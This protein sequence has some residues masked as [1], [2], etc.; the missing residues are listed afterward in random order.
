MAIRFFTE[1]IEFSLPQP[2]KT[3]I[4][5]K[6]IIESQ[7]FQ[8]GEINY[9]FADDEYILQIN[10]QYLQHDTYTDIITF[11]QRETEEK[12][13]SDIYISIERIKENAQNQKVTFEN[14]LKRVIIHG[15]WHLL[16]YGD[17]TEQEAKIMREKENQS[18]ILFSKKN[19]Y[20]KN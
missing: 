14:E 8:V 2:Q 1:N 13:D 17:K 7:G 18:L 10:Q 3:R 11:D 4:W 16:G 9:I 15:I 19:K 12:I 5:I 20:T 6:K